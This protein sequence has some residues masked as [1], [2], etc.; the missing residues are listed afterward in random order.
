MRTFKEDNDDGS[1]EFIGE[2][3]I[4]HTPKNE[5]ITLRTGEAFDIVGEIISEER[6]STNNIGGYTAKLKM[7]VKNHKEIPAEV[8]VKYSGDANILWRN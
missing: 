4:D 8:V 3:N 2:D 1:L 7:I 5:K 6:N